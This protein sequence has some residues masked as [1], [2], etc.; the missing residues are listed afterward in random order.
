MCVIEAVCTSCHTSGWD[1]LWNLD[2][3]LPMANHGHAVAPH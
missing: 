1:P 3:K 2:K